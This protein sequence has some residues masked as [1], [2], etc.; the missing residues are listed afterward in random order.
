M[1]TTIGTIA[2]AQPLLTVEGLGVRFRGS[3][4]TP[5]CRDISFELRP[6]EILGIVGESGSGKSVTCRALMGLLPESAEV[7]GRIE[8]DGL[9]ADLADRRAIARLRGPGLSMIFQ[10]R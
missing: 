1:A 4:D 2:K 10:D 9:K 8:F 3:K 7:S 5:A 6:G